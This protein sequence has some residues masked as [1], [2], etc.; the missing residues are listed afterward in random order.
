MTI[1]DLALTMT[2]GL[3]V[4]GTAHLLECFASADEIFAA[5]SHE[6]I[7]RAALHEEVARR[8][9]R[10]EG[11]RAAEREAEYCRRHGISIVASTDAEYPPL[12][13]LTADYPH[14]IYVRGSIEAL[15]M[16]TLSMVGTREISPSGQHLCDRLV[17]E[18]SER[19]PDLCIVSGL[20]YGVDAA[21]HRAALAYGART[22]AVIANALP[23][24]TPAPHRRLAEEIVARGGAIVSELH[25]QRRQN[26]ALFLAR[27]RIIA[28]MSQGLVVV[29]SPASG[30]S[31][32][33]AAMA[34]GYDRTVM[35]LPGRIT[36]VSSRGTN[37]L[38]RNHKAR[39]VMTADDIIEDMMWDTASATTH[40][41][42]SRAD[43]VLSAAEA[44][45]LACF[46]DGDIDRDRLADA[47]GLSPGELS[48]LLMDLE[49]K[50]AVRP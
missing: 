34:D 37:N 3:G 7:S 36:D 29:E 20:A 16:R 45:L 12:M 42:D 1:F 5:S 41:H 26:G 27:N 19:I 46:T 35:A 40:S 14:V 43:I 38:I 44:T 28:A 4:K 30:G 48:Q 8:I 39:L 49:L 2:P 47:S 24:V 15:H 32:A 25:S 13:R 50:G 11:L 10:R 9:V 21:C 23:D 33:T 17:K 22:V 6:L 31:L 18:L